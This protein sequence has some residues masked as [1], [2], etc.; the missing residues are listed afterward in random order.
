MTASAQKNIDALNDVLG[1]TFR[2][3]VQTHGYHWNVEGPNFRQ[4]HATFEQQYQNLWAALDE[5]AERI[6]TQGA[7]APGTV[8]AL[9]ALAGPEDPPAQSAGDM[10]SKLIAAHEALATTLRD[11]IAVSADAGDEVSAGILT[12]RLEWHEKE[13]W[14]MKAG[15]R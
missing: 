4:L 5:I 2:L 11:A 1:K 8:A 14:M 12:D 15:T 10:V 9:M 13:L 3:Y 7:Y 6:R